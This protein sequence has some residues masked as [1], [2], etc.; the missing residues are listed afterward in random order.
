MVGEGEVPLD[1]SLEL[2]GEVP[3]EASLEL[4]GE[5]PRDASLKLEGVQLVVEELVHVSS[6]VLMVEQQEQEVLQD[7]YLELEVTA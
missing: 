5:V 6:V 3:L 7:F 4:E 1:A 2:E